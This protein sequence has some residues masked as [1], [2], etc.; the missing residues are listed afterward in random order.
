M[1]EDENSN[2]E[3][4][5]LGLPATVG[6]MDDF[7]LG[8]D[9][10]GLG[11]AWLNKKRRPALLQAITA[12][13][14]VESNLGEDGTWIPYAEVATVEVYAHLP[15]VHLSW[16]PSGRKRPGRLAF[17]LAS[18]NQARALF[19]RISTNAGERLELVTGK[20]SAFM[21]TQWHWATLVGLPILMV[22]VIG[23]LDIPEGS[24]AFDSARGR[25]MGKKALLIAAITR[26]LASPHR[27]LARA[28]RGSSL[29]KAAG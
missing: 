26:S 12:S 8:T 11:F 28:A 7:V 17:K 21:M 10:D 25:H 22:F 16:I 4:G 13:D 24:E 14:D 1:T 29:D 3:L 27:Q 20:A 23:F 6:N 2:E 18:M 19:S 15:E 9:I 5:A